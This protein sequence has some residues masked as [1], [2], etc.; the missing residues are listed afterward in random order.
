MT[1]VKQK[2]KDKDLRLLRK[3]P[4]LLTIF[5]F[6][7][8][9]YPFLY[10]G[11]ILFI[12]K[13]YKFGVNNWTD[14]LINTY[15]PIQHPHLIFISLLAIVQG[16]GLYKVRVWA[17]YLFLFGAAYNVSHGAYH[18]LFFEGAQASDPYWRAFVSCAIL[19]STFLVWYFLRK[20]IRAPYFN[21]RLRWWE[22]LPRYRVILNLTLKRDDQT[23]KAKIFD[24]SEGGIFIQCP[25]KLVLGEIVQSGI[26]IE[27]EDFSLKG[28]AV[29][30]S[31]GSSRHPKGV[32]IKFISPSRKYRTTVRSFFKKMEKEL[33]RTR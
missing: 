29:W 21:P 16:Y 12:R 26:K 19:F 23:I 15:D 31:D 1:R 2:L 14:F 11:Q 18:L 24:I 5:A 13:V 6:M 27:D 25:E 7:H 8:F 9:F 22:Q 32:G 17:L 33:E 28:E 3:R 20:E 30:I 4:L 10:F